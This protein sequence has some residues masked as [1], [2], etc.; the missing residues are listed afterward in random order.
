[1]YPSAAHLLDPGLK[2]AAHHARETDRLTLS[3]QVELTAVP[4]PPF[5][6]G[7]RGELMAELMGASGLERP[8]TDGEGNVLALRPGTADLPPVVLCAHLD[9]VFPPETPIVVRRDGDL[10]E[11]PG[12]SDNGRGLAV[13]LAVA[14][15]LDAGGVPTRHPVLF[16]ATVGEEGV[17]DLR[18]ARH[19]V[20]PD[21]AARGAAAFIAVDGAGL[22]QVVT[23]GLGSRRFRLRVRGPGGHSWLDR[24]T[25][26][27]ID[28][29]ARLVT[30]VRM[31][32]P[33][34]GHE[35][36][37]SCGRCGGGT[38]VNAIPEEAWVDVDCRSTSPPHLDVLAEA[39]REA[40]LEAVEPGSRGEKGTLTLE[41]DALG[42]RPAGE[43]DPREAVVHAARLATDAVGVAPRLTLASTDANAAMAAGIPAVTLGGGG[44]AGLAH[45]T[46]EWY[47]NAAGAEGVVR[48][49]YAVALTAGLGA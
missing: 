2:S 38:S 46:R 7:P 34:A 21:G 43:T 22:E 35:W 44:D 20:G 48:A 30:G 24:G 6:E 47:R 16:A 37:F 17:G 12:I 49:L 28:A 3:Q 18:G 45:T 31:P 26:N 15:A 1:V 41:V 25:A 23:R 8:W 42:F 27:P 4:A 39:L 36:T 33:P 11:G 9:T 40:G 13:L 19:L 29:L 14:R 5:A 32:E 10:L